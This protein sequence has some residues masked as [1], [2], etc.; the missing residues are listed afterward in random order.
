[1]LIGCVIYDEFDHDLHIALVRGIQERT[2]IIDRAIYGM[3]IEIIGDVV[4]VVL[5]GREEK[6]QQPETS[7]TKILEIIHLLDQARKITY[8]IGVTVFERAN[9]KLIDDRVLVPERIGRAAGLF[10][11]V[12]VPR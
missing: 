3:D 8:A 7:D 1:M 10:W 5:E 9:V 4:A 6:S 12:C 11:H 2:K